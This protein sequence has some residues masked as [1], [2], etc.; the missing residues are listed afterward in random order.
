MRSTKPNL[1]TSLYHLLAGHPAGTN[2]VQIEER[3]EDIRQAM[4]A[5]LGAAGA[6]HFPMV[7][8]RIV[9]AADAHGLWY[10]RSGLM[11]ALCT[12]H[13]ERAASSEM[14]KLSDMFRGMLPD[15]LASRPSPLSH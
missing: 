14:A 13:G 4:L 2:E 8:R 12:V 6:R 1:G 10:L 5:S 9:G 3:T 11:A 7:T 15:G